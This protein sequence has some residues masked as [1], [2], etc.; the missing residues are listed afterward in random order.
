VHLFAL[1]QV[2]H[3][4]GQALHYW[5]LSA[6]IM[7]KYELVQLCSQTLLISTKP[8]KQ[9]MHVVSDKQISQGKLQG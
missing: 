7:A 8:A 9:L 1:I 5:L 3:C 2:K 4:S 6:F